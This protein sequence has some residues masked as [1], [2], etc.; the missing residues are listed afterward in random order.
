[1]ETRR[2][3][4]GGAAVERSERRSHDSRTCIV[5]GAGPAGLMAAE[6]MARA[7][8][9]VVVYEASASPARKF[10]FAGRG[11]L[12][13]THS[14]PIETFLTRYG[15]ATAG[16][17]RRSGRFRLKHCATGR[18]DSA[19]KPLSAQAGEYFRKALRLPRS[20]GLGCGV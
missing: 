3:D 16:Y 1:M 4:D 2:S 19:K 15:A 5:V 9:R 14:E 11:G 17:V 20:C 13:L 12:N 18:P 6:E 10:L 7:G 8:R